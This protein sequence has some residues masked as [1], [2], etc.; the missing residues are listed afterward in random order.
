M[1]IGTL[2]EGARGFD[3]NAKVTAPIARAFQAAGYSFVVRYVRRST[4]HDYDLSVSELVGLLQSGLAVM[5]VQHVA[6]EGWHPTGNLGASYGAIAAEEA[7]AVG[8]PPGVAVWCD[9]EGVGG[10]D[11]HGEKTDAR[12]VVS[13]CNSWFD[14]VKGAGYDPGL[15]VGFGCVLTG[16]ELYYKLRFRRYWSAYNLNRDNFPAVRGVCMKQGPYPPPSER[17]PGVPFEYDTDVVQRDAF[18]N[19]PTAIL[20]GDPG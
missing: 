2:P 6:A 18:N 17:V 8:I 10:Q 20:P 9:L 7:R 12:D 16:Q 4:R 11:E 3:C 5:V 14:A 15:Y 19:L 1:K 13:F